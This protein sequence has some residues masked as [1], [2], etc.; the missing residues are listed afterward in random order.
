VVLLFNDMGAPS[1]DAGTDEHRRIQR[2]GDPHQKIGDRGVEIQVGT[3]TF[4]LFHDV[5]DGGRNLV[6]SAVAADPA[7]RFSVPLNDG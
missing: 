6:P 2:A 5:I 7:Q 1:G 3:E 4:F